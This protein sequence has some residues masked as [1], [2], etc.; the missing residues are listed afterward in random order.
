MSNQS[1][2]NQAPVPAG[3]YC[4]GYGFG[5]GHFQNFLYRNHKTAQ[6][7]SLRFPCMIS[8]YSTHPTYMNLTGSDQPSKL[9]TR[10]DKIEK[11]K[12]SVG[13]HSKTGQSINMRHDKLDSKVSTP[14]NT[15]MDVEK[16]P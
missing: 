13:Y 1:T 4:S 3:G 16:K 8:V 6:N 2:Y 14:E 5:N 11:K 12:L 10:F 9:M 7:Q 15:M